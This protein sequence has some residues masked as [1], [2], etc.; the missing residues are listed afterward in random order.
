M[1]SHHVRHARHSDSSLLDAKADV[2]LPVAVTGLPDISTWELES[3]GYLVDG[4]GGANLE[5]HSDVA[6]SLRRRAMSTGVLPMALQQFLKCSDN[7]AEV[8]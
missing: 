2:T 7:D 5:K 3:Q 1:S 8:C 4:D 6:L